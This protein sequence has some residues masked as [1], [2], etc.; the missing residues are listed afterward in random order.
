[1][2]QLSKRILHI[3][4]YSRKRSSQST[5][6]RTLG[7]TVDEITENFIK[8]VDFNSLY[9]MLKISTTMTNRTLISP[10]EYKLQLKTLVYDAVLNYYKSKMEGLYNAEYVSI[11]LHKIKSGNIVI[12][13][14]N[15]I[16]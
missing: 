3:F 14:Y 12:T 5:D 13:I 8:L 15:N 2:I 10:A 16:F 11:Y 7:K 1:M 6:I 9:R 4:P